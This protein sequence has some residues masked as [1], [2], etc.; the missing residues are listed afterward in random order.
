MNWCYGA[1]KNCTLLHN[2]WSNSKEHLSGFIQLEADE[3]KKQ[4]LPITSK[5]CELSFFL[6][7]CLSNVYFSSLLDL[8]SADSYHSALLQENQQ[9]QVVFLFL[10]VVLIVV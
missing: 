5:E 3:S 6:L 7:V 8:L 1:H 9:L 4:K 2:S 10:V